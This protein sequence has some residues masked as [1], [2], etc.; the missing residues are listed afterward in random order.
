M[1]KKRTEDTT[2]SVRIK[3]RDITTDPV[4]IKRIVIREYCE[5]LCAHK[6][7]S[8]D[9]MDHFFEHHKLQKLTEDEIDGR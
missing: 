7:S 4:D 8:L 9:K 6:F 5:Q 2:A 3:R 1:T